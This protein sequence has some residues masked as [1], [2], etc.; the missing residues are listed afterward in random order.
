ML[1]DSLAG[2][3]VALAPG[4]RVLEAGESARATF[5]LR[6]G[7]AL[8][9]DLALGPAHA[10]AFRDAMARAADGSAA[11]LILAPGDLPAALAG[12]AG[13]SGS[14]VTFAFA[15]VPG[16][17]GGTAWVLLRI[18]VAAPETPIADAEKPGDRALAALRDSEAR[19]RQLF[20]ANPHPMWVYDRETHAFLAVNDAA[21]R[22]YGWTRDEFMRMTIHDIRPP[23]DVPALLEVLG[24]ERPALKPPA[25]WRHVTRDDRRLEVE[26]A[27]HTLPFGGRPAVLV[28]AHDVTEQLRLEAQLRQA[29][30][31]EAVGRLAGGV[32]HDF[33]NL[34]TVILGYGN[35]VQNRLRAEDPV[36]RDV[37]EIVAVAERAASLTRQL[38]AFSRQQVLET[39]VIDL[40]AIVSDLERMLR[41]L[42]GEDVELVILPQPSLGRVSAD[43]GQVEQVLV[44]LVVNARDAMPA[45]GRLTIRTAD[46]SLD[47]AHARDHADVVPGAYVMIAVTDTGTGMS[48]DVASRAFEPFFTTKERGRGTG[49]GLATVHGIVKQSGGHLELESERGLGSTFRV[50]LPRVAGEPAAASAPEAARDRAAATETVLVVEDEEMIRRVVR[51]GLERKGYRVLEAA[52]GPAALALCGRE[53]VPIDLMVTDVVMPW[54][55]GP[56]LARRVRPLRPGL[57]VI[58]VSGHADRAL[59]GLAAGGAAFLQKPF[60]PEAL[61]RRVREVLDAAAP[62]PGAVPPPAS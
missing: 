3:N 48:L 11:A 55:S 59:D 61:A 30:K 35:L 33:N 14:D 41:R 60:T 27:S 47:A 23:E 5:V 28:H 57:R 1:L 13:P 43:P 7:A 45:G 12:S 44:N 42:I 37:G 6:A 51:E 16:A 46:V 8:P 19:Y 17:E 32:A 34:L 9:D 39:R 40:N 24:A 29:H 52:D 2:L 56:E 36:R 18:L 15:P 49:L 20:L 4:G 22:L 38:L 10:A 50:Y 58:Y 31:M 26:I 53:D 21:V 25:R 54:M 62:G